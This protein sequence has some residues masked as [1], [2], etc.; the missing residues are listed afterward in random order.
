LV[1]TV[2]LEPVQV[3]VEE[4]RGIR[5][6]RHNTIHPSVLVVLCGRRIEAVGYADFG[7]T[8]FVVSLHY[9]EHLASEQSNEASLAVALTGPFRSEAEF[10]G[11]HNLVRWLDRIAED[12]RR[13]DEEAQ[14]HLRAFERVAE[15]S[16]PNHEVRRKMGERMRGDRGNGQS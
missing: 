8:A 6:T 15:E 11:C 16:E 7:L 2:E 14:E 13:R 1:S 5:Y 4:A 12:E 10:H 9:A 3:G